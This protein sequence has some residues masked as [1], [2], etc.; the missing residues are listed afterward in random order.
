MSIQYTFHNTV[1][2]L[3]PTCSVLVLRIDQVSDALS[4]P[5]R[6]AKEPV[7]MTTEEFLHFYPRLGNAQQCVTVSY[8]TFCSQRES[9]ELFWRRFP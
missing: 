9:S 1:C 6:P 3:E 7:A 5:E 2:C 4:K 8:P